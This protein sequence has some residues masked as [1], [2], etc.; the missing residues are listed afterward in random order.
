MP[1]CAV[2]LGVALEKTGE[3]SVAAIRTVIRLN[4]EYKFTERVANLVK[5]AS[6]TSA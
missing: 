5:Q 4:K 2:Q 6:S 3:L 1:C